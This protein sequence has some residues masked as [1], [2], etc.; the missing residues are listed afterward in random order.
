[1]NEI[2][3]FLEENSCRISLVDIDDLPNIDEYAILR[4]LQQYGAP[5]TGTFAPKFEPGYVVEQSE[6]YLRQEI[7]YRWYKEDGQESR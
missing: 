3:D 2:D 1:M 4:L 5:I 7:T 6:D